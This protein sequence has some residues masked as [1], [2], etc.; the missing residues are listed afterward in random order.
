M[1]H[2][3]EYAGLVDGDQSVPAFKFKFVYWRIVD[4]SGVVDQ[5]IKT[6]FLFQHLFYGC[7][8]VIFFRNIGFDERHVLSVICTILDVKRVDEGTLLNEFI[9]DS[10]TDS[11]VSSRDDCDFVF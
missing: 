3:Q 4:D 11:L 6:P 5:N 1:L 10:Q 9:D 2:P 7:F 8:P